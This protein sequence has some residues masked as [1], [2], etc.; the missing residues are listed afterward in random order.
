MGWLGWGRLKKPLCMGLGIGA[1]VPASALTSCM[2]LGSTLSLPRPQ[3]Y[4][5]YNV[6]AQI[7]KA[8]LRGKR[9]V[10]PSPLSLSSKWPERR[11][12]P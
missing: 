2:S 9:T 3:F 1:S 7:T 11:Q 5:L 12:Y 6:G 10:M 4:P 8:L